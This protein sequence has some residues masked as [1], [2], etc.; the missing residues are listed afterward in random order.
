MVLLAALDIHKDVND[1]GVKNNLDPKSYQDILRNTLKK[2]KKIR[3][4]SIPPPQLVD[5]Y[6][7]NGKINIEEYY[8]DD[9]QSFVKPKVYTKEVIDS[10]IEKA[11]RKEKSYYGKTDLW[12]YQ[13]LQKF[14]IDNKDVAIMGSATPWYES[15]CLAYG[16]KPT[17]IEYN[18]IITKDSRLKVMTVD[19]YDQNPMRFDAAFS[20]SSFEHDGLGRYGDPLNPNGDLEVM[21]KMKSIL[22]PVG[23]LFLAV[24]IGTDKVVWNNCRGYGRIRLPLLLK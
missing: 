9:T 17:T 19:E 11:K 24:P 13:A 14:P 20:I 1:L 22:K 8:L 10:L 3:P 5:K 15:I 4:L 21:T 16:G 6:T 12:L 7:M 18:K 23:I 2:V